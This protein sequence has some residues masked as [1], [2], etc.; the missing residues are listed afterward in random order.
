MSRSVCLPDKTN[1]NLV[2]NQMQA[3]FI[4]E[5]PYLD[6]VYAFRHLPT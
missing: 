4:L 3:I 6:K 1:R 5:R 2:F